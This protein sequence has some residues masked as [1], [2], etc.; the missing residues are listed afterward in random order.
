MKDMV[1]IEEVCQ[2]CIMSHIKVHYY[3]SHPTLN[4]YGIIPV[5]PDVMR[6]LKM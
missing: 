5:G 6:S 2:T 1:A 3:T 4:A